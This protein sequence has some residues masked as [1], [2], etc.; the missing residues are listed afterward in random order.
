ML[1]PHSYAELRTILCVCTTMEFNCFL[2][3]HKYL[4][5]NQQ[6]QL[7]QH[8]A[9]PQRWM[10]WRFQ[11]RQQ[12]NRV[13]ALKLNAVDAPS[14]RSDDK[15]CMCNNNEGFSGILHTHFTCQMRM[16][17]HFGYG[18]EDVIVVPVETIQPNIISSHMRLLE[19]STQSVGRHPIVVT[20]T[21]LGSFISEYGIV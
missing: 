18:S 8:I 1:L 21:K 3:R 15:T 17:F 5:Q 19:N 12:R 16:K 14:A 10:K 2:N 7:Q 20:T 6:Q 4:W 11:L 13:K 9:N